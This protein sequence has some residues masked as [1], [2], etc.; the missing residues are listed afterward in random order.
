MR[1]LYA[2][3]ARLGGLGIAN[4]MEDA[5]F[6]YENSKMMT[7]QLT[8]A[9]FEQRT[10]FNLDEE[11]HNLAK[12]ELSSRKATKFQAIQE[13]L[14]GA[15]SEDMLKVVELSA[16][17]GASIWLTSI[18][19]KKFGFRLNKLQFSDALSMRYNARLE[20]VPRNCSCGKEYSINHCL[21]CKN[22][23]FVILRHNAVRDTTHKLMEQ[24]CK[25][26]CLEPKL[27]P[28]TGEALPI[29]ANKA[30]G[31][32]ADVSAL[33]FWHP[34]CRAFFDIK[35]FNP[36]A[37]SN[38]SKKIPDMY[39]H[40]E[41]LKKAE[42]NDRIMQVDKGTFTPMIFSC[43]GGAAP[44]ATKCLKT[45][46]LKL[47]KKRQEPYSAVMN[48]VRRRFRF[49]LLKTCV[50]SFRGERSSNVGGSIT[51]LEFGLCRLD[52]PID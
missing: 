51:D 29:S 52:I 44:E 3:P 26:V 39:T 9:I 18:P 40:H 14:K 27:L 23:G 6:E 31:A 38:W 49:D 21:S 41:H 15:L 47:S 28:V 13:E 30:D 17:K 45:L 16:E 2:L 37:Q 4:P 46:A 12:R 32:R 34:L 19:L 8:E 50:L 36:F 7:E 5:D 43:S 48:F 1:K 33:N 20:D 35:V 24:V 11:R 10:S 25:D 22:G 42:Y